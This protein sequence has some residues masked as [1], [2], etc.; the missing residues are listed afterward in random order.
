MSFKRHVLYPPV[1][2]SEDSDDVRTW[3]YGRHFPDIRGFS[4]ER[5][6]QSRE[7][8][9]VVQASLV[10]LVL[11]WGWRSRGHRTG[12]WRGRGRLR[13]YTERGLIGEVGGVLGG[14]P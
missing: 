13:T 2:D 9:K 5:E 7:R 12:S 4:T 11:S 14:N 6:R 3:I 10:C 8:D 1:Y